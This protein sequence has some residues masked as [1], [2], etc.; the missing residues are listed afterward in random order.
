MS[1]N[2]IRGM[3]RPDEYVPN[4]DIARLGNESALAFLAQIGGHDSSGTASTPSR[5]PGAPEK[6]RTKIKNN[7]NFCDWWVLRGWC[8]GFRASNSR[9]FHAYTTKLM[10]W[11]SGATV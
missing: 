9:F 6:K 3:A 7:T 1:S 10:K 8:F 4:D 11:S 5:S 2:I